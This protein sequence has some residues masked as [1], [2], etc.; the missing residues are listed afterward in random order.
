VK[1]TQAENSD[2]RRNIGACRTLLLQPVLLSSAAKHA[3]LGASQTV[4]KTVEPEESGNLRLARD[5]RRPAAAAD[6]LHDSIH[7]GR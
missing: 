2:P 7:S 6:G 1:I 5:A 3:L 4:M